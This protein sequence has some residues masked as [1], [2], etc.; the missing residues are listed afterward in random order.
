M[1]EAYSLSELAMRPSLAQI[2]ILLVTW[3][4]AHNGKVEAKIV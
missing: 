1:F 4:I 2:G 3:S